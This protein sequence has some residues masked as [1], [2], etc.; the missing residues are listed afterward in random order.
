[1]KGD[2]PKIVRRVDQIELQTSTTI[3]WPIKM[4]KR[5]SIWLMSE[6]QVWRNVS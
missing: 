4:N 2:D 1:M 6:K 3:D 5:Y